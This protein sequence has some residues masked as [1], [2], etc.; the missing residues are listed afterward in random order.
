MRLLLIGILSILSCHVQAIGPKKCIRPSPKSANVAAAPHDA[1]PIVFHPSYDISFGGLEKILHSFDGS[2]YGKVFSHLTQNLGLD[3]KR[4]FAP[5]GPITDEQL[6]RVHTQEYLSSLNQSS[7]TVARIA[8]VALLAYLPNF[9]I[10]RILLTPM[11]WATAGAIRATDLALHH[12][13]AINLGGGYH[14][15]KHDR[16]S[17]FCV[18]ADIS[19]AALHALE[20]YPDKVKKVLIIDLDAHQG[21]GH[22]AI[23]IHMELTESVHI[24][25]LYNATIYP[26]DRD[27]QDGIDYNIPVRSGIQDKAYL[28]L[29][30]Y[31]VPRALNATQPDLIIYNAG[32][33][34]FE[35]DP[36]G[37]MNIS[38]QGIIARDE[39]VF[40]QAERRNIPIVMILS[41][42]Y[43]ND[44]ADIISSSLENILRK[45]K[46]L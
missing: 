39:F 42:G 30:R 45:K 35:K 27:A 14:H 24:F 23:N 25:D 43:T 12:G 20:T 10:Q 32:S 5:E 13:W 17:G 3:S 2:K 44:S 19:L 36:L 29:L 16:G 38:A 41:G 28:N 9:V 37:R 40:R 4:T 7:R 34:I 15:A 21:N 8:E 26:Q 11:R 6:S 33:D 18:F 31:H 46:V 22:E 1:I